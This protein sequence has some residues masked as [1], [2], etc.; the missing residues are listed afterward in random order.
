MLIELENI[1][2]HL[3]QYFDS[4]ISP[5]DKQNNI[6]KAY[7]HLHRVTLDCYKLLWINIYD[8]LE[9]IEKDKSARRLGLNISEADFLKRLQKIRRLAQEARRKEEA[10]K[11]GR[12][13]R[14]GARDP[15]G[16]RWDRAFGVWGNQR[17]HLYELGILL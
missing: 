4:E 15:V 14:V 12:S 2:S 11:Q 10:K 17:S 5:E 7:D 16:A 13:E 8:E 1:L 6:Q 9:E 3:S